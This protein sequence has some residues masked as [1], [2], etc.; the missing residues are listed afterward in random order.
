ML[1]WFRNRFSGLGVGQGSRIVA[2]VVVMGTLMVAA[3]LPLV[4]GLGRNARLARS[5]SEDLVPTSIRVMALVN[6]ILEAQSALE[7]FLLTGEE[8]ERTRFVEATEL[9]HITLPALQT[10]EPPQGFE[11]A[12]SLQAMI[13]GI[14]DLVSKLEAQ[15]QE[16]FAL[17]DRPD[18]VKAQYLINTRG[19]KLLTRAHAFIDLIME[20]WTG[21]GT[22]PDVLTLSALMGFQDS[23]TRMMSNMRGY[24][25][26]REPLFREQFER[27]RQRNQRI[28]NIISERL[29]TE[30]PAV[31]SFVHGL[32]VTR[33]KLLKTFIQA[34]EQR[35][36]TAWRRDLAFYN[37]ELTPT[38]DS[39]KWVLYTLSDT[40]N[41]AIST[42]STQ[43]TGHGLALKRWVFFGALGFLLLGGLLGVWIY[44]CV[45]VFTR[46]IGDASEILGQMSGKF[47]EET[48]QQAREAG[49]QVEEIDAVYRTL[50]E[51]K[52]ALSEIRAQTEEMAQQTDAA[53][54]ECVQGMEVLGD[55]QKRMAGI[56]AQSREITFA[57]AE[58]RR[59]TEQMDGILAILNELVDQTKLLSFNATIEAAGA[60]RSGHR[61]AVVAKQVRRLAT[62]AQ[63][64]TQEIRQMIKQVQETAESTRR[65]TERGTDAINEGENLMNVVT[66]RLDA[67]VGAVSQVSDMAG[68]IFLATQAQDKSVAQ[69]DKFVD[70]AKGTAE[71]VSSRTE[72][73][74]GTAQQLDTTAKGLA[75]LVGKSD[76]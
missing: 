46:D 40:T 2:A 25:F 56:L 48:E 18:N 67:I 47:R 10:A 7:A 49:H 22:V 20:T 72:Q 29:A 71:R 59:Q 44:H 55:S 69:V 57:M 17:R 63:E 36:A 53:S 12:E 24:L 42:V 65:A 11:S 60:G 45:R 21:A 61:F 58:T 39:L 1:N 37:T 6:S 43:S 76:A 27:E 34:F 14:S 70:E 5:V 32:E 9:I 52:R 35:N 62:R 64:A 19:E 13:N 23:M 15:A 75:R 8:R 38:L 41:Q 3:A 16:V 31:E 26:M 51:L 54:L 33:G 28:F 66:E 30:N 74:R 73:T 50:M 68:R 4:D